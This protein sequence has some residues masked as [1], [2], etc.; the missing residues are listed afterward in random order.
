MLGS[1]TY[2]TIV[3]IST[4]SRS[5]D[6][7]GSRGAPNKTPWADWV[8]HARRKHEKK[9]EELETNPLLQHFIFQFLGRI[10]IWH[11]INL[12]IHKNDAV[13]QFH[14]AFYL[15]SLKHLVRKTGFA[16]IR[17]VQMEKLSWAMR[18]RQGYPDS[19]WQ[20]CE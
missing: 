20:R 5:C 13:L 10:S 6:L 16:I 2:S 7:M 8:L 19:Q 4:G 1:W 17:R 14:S 12:K 11:L 15:G 9:E 3:F 18:F